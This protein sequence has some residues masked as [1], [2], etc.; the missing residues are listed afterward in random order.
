MYCAGIHTRRNWILNFRRF[1]RS[2]GFM[3]IN[4]GLQKNGFESVRRR[5]RRFIT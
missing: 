3:G 1:G 5:K 4:K 2:F